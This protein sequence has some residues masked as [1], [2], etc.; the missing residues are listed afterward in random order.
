MT[1]KIMFLALKQQ[2]YL[3]IA[4]SHIFFQKKEP[5]DFLFYFNYNLHM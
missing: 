3:Q 2:C 1:F 5:V 4:F